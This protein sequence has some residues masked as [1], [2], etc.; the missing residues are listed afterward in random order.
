MMF[1]ERMHRPRS[2]LKAPE[3]QA[4]QFQPY[5]FTKLKS[6]TNELLPLYNLCPVSYLSGPGLWGSSF[7]S[8]ASFTFIFIVLSVTIKSRAR[9]CGHTVMSKR[10]RSM[11]QAAKMSCI[12]VMV[13]AASVIEELHHRMSSES[14]WLDPNPSEPEFKSIFY[15]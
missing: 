12:C 3:T 15:L 13:G 7:S 10:R 5:Y 2:C 9:S 1:A 6:S 11:I 14:R 8:K 4:L